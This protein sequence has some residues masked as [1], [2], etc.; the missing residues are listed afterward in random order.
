MHMERGDLTEAQAFFDESLGYFEDSQAIGERSATLASLSSL[1]HMR[2]EYDQAVQLAEDAV[3]CARQSGVETRVMYALADL[4]TAA[5]GLGDYERAKA[6]LQEALMYSEQ[7]GVPAMSGACLANLG[8]LAWEQGQFEHAQI[9]QER[10]VEVARTMGDMH[11][12]AIG[13]HN[14]AKVLISRGDAPRAVTCMSHGLQLIR[15]PD[16][17]KWIT[18]L[19]L[20]MSAQAL[21]ADGRARAAASLGAVSSRILAEVGYAPSPREREMN[22]GLMARARS[23]LDEP[24]WEQAWEAGE[25]MSLEQAVDFALS[26]TSAFTARYPDPA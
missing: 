1:A 7:L 24:T 10:A 18:G 26:N 3:S 13:L 19:L 5:T 22:E 20:T 4:G 15:N 2:G 12:M 6:A 11:V 8:E 14:L 23:M 16:G 21:S 9:Y 17:E 25:A